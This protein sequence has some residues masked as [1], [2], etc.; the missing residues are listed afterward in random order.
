MRWVSKFLKNLRFIFKPMFW[1]MD[2]RYSKEWDV[3][4]NILLD[5]HRFRWIKEYTAILGDKEIWIDNYPYGSFT[6]E[7]GGVFYRPSRLT[8]M[9]AKRLLD[10]DKILGDDPFFNLLVDLRKSLNDIKNPSSTYNGIGVM[11]GV[12]IKKHKFYN[13]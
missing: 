2:Y 10:R 1:F 8:I 7:E 5:N 6:K 11:G 12:K 13:K 3:E 9:R 4:L